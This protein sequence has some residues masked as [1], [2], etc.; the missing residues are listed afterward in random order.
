MEQCRHH[1]GFILT[2]GASRKVLPRLHSGAAENSSLPGS[3][4]LQLQEHLAGRW[5]VWTG[6]VYHAHAELAP[7]ASCLETVELQQVQ[8]GQTQRQME[9][10]WPPPLQVTWCDSRWGEKELQR[11]G[12]ELELG[13]LEGSSWRASVPHQWQGS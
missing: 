10:T 9:V 8:A 13:H 1:V 7:T 12:E 3:G 4:A 6:H 5:L 11:R 2:V